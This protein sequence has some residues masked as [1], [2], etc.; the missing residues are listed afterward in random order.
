MRSERAA[1]EEG[2]RGLLW[3]ASEF[4]HTHPLTPHGSISPTAARRPQRGISE[5]TIFTREEIVEALVAKVKGRCDNPSDALRLMREAEQLIRKDAHFPE[6]AQLR[7]DLLSNVVDQIL[8][9]LS[10]KN[11]GREQMMTELHYTLQFLDSICD[12]NQPP[13]S[14]VGVD[15]IVALIDELR[16]LQSRPSPSAS[17][18]KLQVLF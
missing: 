18:F 2:W 6:A 13:S 17:Y 14:S 9:N 15:S 5:P 4:T 1:R 3:S 16:K 11:E 10:H 7:A 12:N 8:Y